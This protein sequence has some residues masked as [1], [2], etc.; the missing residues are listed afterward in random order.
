M[1]VDKYGESEIYI[2][3]MVLSLIPIASIYTASYFVDTLGRW[4]LLMMS[5]L[6]TGLSLMTFI[7]FPANSRIS[8]IVFY[9]IFGA[10]SLFM[11]VLWSVTYLYTPEVYP[12][13]VW[14][15]ALAM[16]NVFDKFA[17]IG[18]P[19]VMSIIVYTSFRLSMAIFGATYLLT[20]IFSMLLTKETANKPMMDSF[21]T[22]FVD[23]ET[24]RS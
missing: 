23:N 2:F 4:F 14:S 13:P 17:S 18:Q 5:S 9:V 19:M 10:Y 7:A 24:G 3:M 12:T 22:D 21:S 16:M 8:I 20:F 1:F 15:T 6:I 11:K